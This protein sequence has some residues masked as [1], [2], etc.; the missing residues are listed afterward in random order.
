M[1]KLKKTRILITAGGTGGHIFPALA[2]ARECVERGM[3]VSFVTDRRFESYREFA[4]G[5]P[6]KIISAASPSG[7]LPKKIAALCKLELGTL[8]ALTHMVQFRPKLVVGFGGYPSF[9]SLAAAWL[10]KKPM[11]LHEQ[12]AVLGKVNRLMLPKIDKLALTFSDTKKVD[13]AYQSKIVVTGNPVRSIFQDY[14]ASPSPRK[15]NGKLH[16]LILGGSQGAKAF[17]KLI[18][19]AIESLPKTVKSTLQI[20]Q[21]CKE[22]DIATVKAIYQK[23]GIEAKLAPFFTNIPELLKTAHLTIA[24]AGASTI[25]EITTIGTAS[26]L[27]PYPYATDQHQLLNAKELE[28][29]Q[30]A[31]VIEEQNNS[32]AEL[33]KTLKRLFKD[34]KQLKTMAENAQKLSQPKAVEKIVKL[35]T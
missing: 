9:P 12:N 28:E 32:T 26:I 33:T 3:E 7:S 27:I 31:V 34:P 30:A 29:A 4:K 21:Q 5:I 25:A 13:P 11:M 10:L 19:E 2:V 6:V 16:I 17:S 35:L 8:Q 15:K 14:A 24:R 1:H 20:T 23:S 22:E 18:P